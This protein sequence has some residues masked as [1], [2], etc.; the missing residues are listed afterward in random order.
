MSASPS[1]KTERFSS[2]HDS[3][4]QEHLLMIEE[5][6]G[7]RD[8]LAA[9]IEE[10]AIRMERLSKG[11]S[12]SASAL[13]GRASTNEKETSIDE[14]DKAWKGRLVEAADEIEG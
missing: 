1:R 3:R 12:S 13:E 4:I 11:L 8:D 5:L 10:Q 9:T 7:E 6:E 2:A 14:L